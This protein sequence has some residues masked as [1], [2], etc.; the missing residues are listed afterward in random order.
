MFALFLLSLSL[1]GV[2]L[3]FTGWWLPEATATDHL[4]GVGWLLVAIASALAVARRDLRY[5]LPVSAWLWFFS[6]LW[7]WWQ[8][9]SLR[10]LEGFLYE[11]SL[12]LTVLV[13]SHVVALVGI[14]GNGQ[15]SPSKA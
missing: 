6:S 3:L 2:L 14:P 15:Q 12:S 1:A 13:L 9:K 5:L 7:W 8:M 10:S 11:D 4:L